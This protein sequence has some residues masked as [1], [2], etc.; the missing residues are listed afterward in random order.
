MTYTQPTAQDLA[1]AIGD[2]VDTARANMLI[3]D[4]ELLCLDIVNPLPG[5][6]AVVVK[7]AAIRAYANITG[8]TAESAGQETVQ[9]GLSG[10]GV[11]LTK[12][13]RAV[14]R[15]A[16]GLGGA[17]SIDPTDPTKTTPY[18]YWAQI[19]EDPFTDALQAGGGWSDWPLS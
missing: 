9:H 15:R 19:P 14:L 11:Y 3:A 12:N 2:G 6:A 4:A 10:A 8:A 16:A 17:F 18:D 1:T 7:A 13:E 5:S